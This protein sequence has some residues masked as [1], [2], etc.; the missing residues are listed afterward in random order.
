MKI[1]K[2]DMWLNEKINEYNDDPKNTIIDMLISTIDIMVQ[3]KDNPTSKV[4]KGIFDSCIENNKLFLIEIGV[5]P[6]E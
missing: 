1:K 4:S 3:Y 2:E 6:N 5:I